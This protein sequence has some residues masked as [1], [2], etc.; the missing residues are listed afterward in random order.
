MDYNDDKQT[1]YYRYSNH[2]PYSNQNGE[3]YCRCY[4]EIE[5]NYY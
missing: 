4:L 1:N 5:V 2:Y 3:D